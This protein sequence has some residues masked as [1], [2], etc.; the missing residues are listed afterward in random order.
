MRVL[1]NAA[2]VFAESLPLAEA[3]ERPSLDHVWP[4]LLT[5]TVT[6]IDFGLSTLPATSAYLYKIV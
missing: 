1:H 4:L 2:R 5:A 6:V 3:I